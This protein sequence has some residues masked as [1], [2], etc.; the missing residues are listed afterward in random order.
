MTPKNETSERELLI[1]RTL[2]APKELIWNAWTKA[3]H[4][5]QWW[6]AKGF[7]I[8]VH[9]LDLIPD[10]SFHYSMTT[11]DGHQ[12][13]G[14]FVYKEIQ[15]PNRLVFI[16]YFSDEYG[17]ITRAPWSNTW[18]LQ[19]LNTLNLTETEGKTALILTGSPIDATDEEMDMFIKAIGNMQQGFNG[20]FERL[21]EYL[22]IL[23]D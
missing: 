5:A 21:E 14:K 13:W 22:V 18:P 16:N 1:T 23:K 4:I 20:T 7:Q 19:V 12:L 10:G 8:V 15:A 17:G 6:G 9:E 2:N 11:P 3:E